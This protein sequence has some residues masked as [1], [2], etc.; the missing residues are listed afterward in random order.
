M[1]L[2]V[3]EC[4]RRDCGIGRGIDRMAAVRLNISFSF[5]KLEPPVSGRL[6]DSKA[7]S[8]V[9]SRQTDGLFIYHAPSPYTLLILRILAFAASQA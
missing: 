8:P 5:L 7:D 6:L 4:L 9:S 3:S 2:N 1:R